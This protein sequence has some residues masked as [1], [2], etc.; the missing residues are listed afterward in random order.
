VRVLLIFNSIEHS[1]A[2]VMLT[3]AAPL[4]RARG[5]ELHALSTGTQPGS[6][7]TVMA[8]SGI[9]VHHRPLRKSPVYFVSLVRF[10]RAS[11]FGV[12]HISPERAFFWY[13]LSARLAGVPL[14]V[15]QVHN[16]FP[17]QGLLRVRRSVQRR[18]S[19]WSSGLW[20]SPRGCGPS[21][22]PAPSDRSR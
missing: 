3:Q 14:V 6:F 18:V 15:R 13:T 1:G 4:M 11:R 2:E 19:C 9:V 12:V 22:T 16:V 17:F 5:I 21:S 8:S 20:S 10:L 7:A